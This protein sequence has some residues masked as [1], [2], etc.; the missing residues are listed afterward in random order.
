MSLLGRGHGRRRAGDNAP[1]ASNGGDSPTSV[2]ILATL[3]L[4]LVAVFTVAA[5]GYASVI[6]HDQSA[7]AL[8]GTLGTASLAA[9]VV[10]SGGRHD[11]G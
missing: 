8:L 11:D 3:A 1:L 10:L 4:V 7:T 2:R 9:L 6:Q 5:I